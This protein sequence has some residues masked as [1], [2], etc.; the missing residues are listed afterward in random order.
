MRLRTRSRLSREPGVDALERLGRDGC[1]AQDVLLFEHHDR[2]S[3]LGEIASGNQA[4]VT[5]ADDCDV[6]RNLRHGASLGLGAGPY[7][8]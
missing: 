7:R 3:G 8:T 4:V 6:A 2:E 5:S 1:A